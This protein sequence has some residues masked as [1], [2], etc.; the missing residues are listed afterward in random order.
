MS[1][2]ESM[3]IDMLDAF[4]KMSGNYIT[5]IKGGKR[6]PNPG[7]LMD[8]LVGQLRKVPGAEVLPAR[9]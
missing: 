3:T 7:T 5:T 1:N 2:P 8:S 4:R 9:K 6:P